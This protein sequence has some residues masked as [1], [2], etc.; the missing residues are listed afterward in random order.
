MSA[1]FTLWIGAYFFQST[2]FLTLHC[3]AVK[4]AISFVRKLEKIHF[5]EA[6]TWGPES[7]SSLAVKHSSLL[8]AQC[9]RSIVWAQWLEQNYKW[10]I[11]WRSTQ[12]LPSLLLLSKFHTVSC[13]RSGCYFI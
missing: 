6:Y 10:R 11:S 5:L 8:P 2:K 7:H 13:H 12:N 3:P 9:K 4:I 1:R